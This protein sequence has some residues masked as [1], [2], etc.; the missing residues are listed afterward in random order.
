MAAP[1]RRDRSDQT[2]RPIRLAACRGS[3]EVAHPSSVFPPRP[4]PSRSFKEDDLVAAWGR[5]G[6]PGEGSVHSSRTST[7][8]SCRGG[9][10]TGPTSVSTERLPWLAHPL[11]VRRFELDASGGREAAAGRARRL[12]RRCRLPASR[13]VPWTLSPSAGCTAR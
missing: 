3:K 8:S 9:P 1:R 4:G 7:S 13:F 10:A 2:D 5:T 11:P 12:V 6:R